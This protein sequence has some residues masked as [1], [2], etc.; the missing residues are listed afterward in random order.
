MKTSENPPAFPT[1]S[2]DKEPGQP[3]F[4]V[5]HGGMFLRDYFA[6][7]AMQGWLASYSRE[8]DI[9]PVNNDCGASVAALSYELADIMLAARQKGAKE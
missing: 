2:T 7:K 1:H 9:H 3:A 4:Q 8:G 6:A 5:S